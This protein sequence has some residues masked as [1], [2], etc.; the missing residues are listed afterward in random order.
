ML[1]WSVVAIALLIALT[2]Q[3]PVPPEYADLYALLESKLKTAESYLTARWEGTKH[4]VVFSTE[5]L[6][7]NSNQ[8]ERV[9]TERAWESILFNLNRIQLLGVRAVKVAVKY[10][11]LMPQFP[12]S[13]EYLA[14]YK[15]LGDELRRRNLKFLVQMTPGFKP[16]AL[17]A[18]P[19][20]PYYA[21]LTLERYKREKRQMAEII[22]REIRPDYLTIENEPKT[23]QENTG[24]PFTVQNFTEIVQYIL[25]GL[26]R[27]GVLIGAGAGTW[28]NLAYPESLARSTSVDYIDIHIYPINFDFLIDRALQ[29]AEIARRYNKKLF[30]GEAWLYKTRDAEL[31]GPPVAAAPGLYARDVFSFWEPLDVKFVETVWKLV[32]YLK[33][34]FASLFWM[35]YF[36]GYVEHT[37]RTKTLSPAELFQLANLEAAKNMLQ[38]PPKLTQ[39]GLTF[40][41]L[42][43][44]P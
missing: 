23:A 30:L 15:K 17:S 38:D 31:F 2:T 24:L 39:T 18:L 9:L 13:A 1:R 37:E 40:Q 6:A 16:S 3:P 32:H 34:D 19:V 43:A 26:E 21:N 5:L 27:A 20:E 41:R 14:L 12:R 35:R 44:K 42:I 10:P 22:I 7:A 33:I 11:I 8:G 28:D 25:N 4:P 29:I 36:F